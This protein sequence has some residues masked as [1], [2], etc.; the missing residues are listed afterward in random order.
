MRA[1]SD[2]LTT[3]HAVAVGALLAVM[4]VVA[5]LVPVRDRGS[6]LF[7]SA[8]SA[9]ATNLEVATPIDV[10]PS[11][12]SSNGSP[13]SEVAVAE[14][15]TPAPT[16]TE[17]VAAVPTT[18]APLTS[19]QATISSA[20]SPPATTVATSAAP[21]SSAP[22]DGRVAVERIQTVPAVRDIIVEIG[23]RR[24]AT[25]G[26]GS[27][28]VPSDLSG[29]PVQ[30]VGLVAEPQIQSVGMIAWSDGETSPQRSLADVDGPVLLL[31][32]ELS[33]RVF[34]EV[35]PSLPDLDTVEFVSSDGERISL[36]TSGP[37]WVVSDRVVNDGDGEFGTERL[38]YAIDTA[39]FDDI[40]LASA[41]YQPRPEAV[42][43]VGGR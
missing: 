17:Q 2:E 43:R 35:D 21:T 6:E 38:E 16:A 20:T 9:P 11:T 23:G 42:W 10:A 28:S 26:S 12:G 30:L 19:S 25:D 22:A 39:Q 8:A 4:T 1:D 13:T 40:A 3:S 5:L 27:I 34:V 14:P 32:L 37:S 36:P 41:T 18:S 7:A 24:L 31:G 33:S 15:A 29:S